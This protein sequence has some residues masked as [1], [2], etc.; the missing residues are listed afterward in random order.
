M[1]SNILTVS[2]RGPKKTAFNFFAD[3]PKT[4]LEFRKQNSGS[5][6]NVND[7]LLGMLSTLK[8]YAFKIFYMEIMSSGFYDFS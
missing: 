4:L 8:H 6:F 7:F 1:W 5:Y 2:C 3:S